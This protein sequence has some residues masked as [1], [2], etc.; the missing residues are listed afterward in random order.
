[1][2]LRSALGIVVAIAVL[3]L[4]GGAAAASAKRVT[5]SVGLRQTQFGKVLVAA[6]GRVLY[7]FKHDKSTASTCYGACATDWPPLLTAAKPHAGAGIRAG[8]LGTTRRKDGKLQVTYRGHPLY[9]FFL[10]KQ[11]GQTKGQGQD[12]F[13]GKWYVLSAAGRTVTKSATSTTTSSTTTTTGPTTTCAYGG[14]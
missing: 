10:D 7:L 4:A 11:A 2:R 13:G 14:C 12:F 8:L 6:N 9:L 5:A 3:A 1:M